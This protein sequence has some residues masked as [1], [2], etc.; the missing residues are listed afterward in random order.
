[1]ET[2][3]DPEV[4][5]DAAC[6]AMVA[7]RG[8]DAQRTAR[9]DSVDPRREAL[10]VVLGFAG[11]HVKGS[12]VLDAPRAWVAESHPSAS[13]GPSAAALIDWAGELGNQLLGRVKNRCAALGLDFA[14]GM[15]TVVMAQEVSLYSVHPEH[16]AV[17]WFQCGAHALAASLELQRDAANA[18]PLAPVEVLGEGDLLI[19]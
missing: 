6:R 5:L 14:L 13:Q 17:L 2:P 16:R 19:F 8:Y 1:M 4:L 7:S 9:P 18:P 15:P 10:Y 11:A 3:F 12:L